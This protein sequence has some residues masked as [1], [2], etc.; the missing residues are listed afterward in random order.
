MAAPAPLS[1]SGSLPLPRTRL[2][3]RDAERVAARALLL[4][5]AVPLLTL[6]GPGG[7]GKTR[8]ALQVAADL[9]EEFAD[10]VFFVPLATIRDADAFLPTVARALGLGDMGSR[11]LQERLVELVQPRQMLLVLDNLEQ[12]TA[13]APLIA[14]LLTASPRLT[15]LA[16]S[17]TVLYLSAEH[18]LPISPLP[19]SV[20][21]G[22]ATFAQIASADAVRLFVDRARAA[23]PDFVLTESNAATVA[24]ICARL[25]GLPL[26]I[27][28]A[29][30]RVGHLPLPAILSRLEE[31]LTFLTGG[32]RD[33]PD[34][35]RTLRNAMTWSYDLLPADEQRLLRSLAVFRGGFSLE[36][37]EDVGGDAALWGRNG[38]QRMVGAFG[39][40]PATLSVL[41][42]HYPPKAK[43]SP[44][45]RR[46]SP[47]VFEGLASL[48]DKS[49]IRLDEAAQEPRY[50]MLE[51]VREFAFERL[52]AGGEAEVVQFAHLA[53]FLALAE[54]AAPEWWGRE[55][56]A[57][58]DRLASE[59]D[60]LRAALGWAVERGQMALGVRL[61]IALHW[62]WR[63]RGPVHEGRHWTA[64]MLLRCAEV[65]PA[66]HAALLPRA[67]DLAT[68]QGDFTRARA[69]LD[70]GIAMARE[71]DDPRLLTFALG[72]RGASAYTAGD[73]GFARTCLEEA[74]SLARANAV[75]L[76]NALAAALLA[77]VSIQLGDT[78]R[79]AELIADVH[80]S[81]RAGEI[82]WTT[83]LIL[84]IEGFLAADHG[85]FDRANRLYRENVTLAWAMRDHRFFPGAVTGFAWTAAARGDP[86]L[87][88]R[89]CGAVDAYRAVTG[90]YLT[91]TGQLSYERALALGQAAI[92]EVACEAAREAGRAL[93]PEAI[94]AEVN[95]KTSAEAGTGA[96]QRTLP[97]E[98]YGLTPRE[99][100]VLRLMAQGRTNR[101]IADGLFISHRTATTHVTNILG[102][103]GVSSRTEATAWAVR[104]GLA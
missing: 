102:K 37:A 24:A 8:L 14:D 15:I 39:A 10:G 38:D 61:A 99:R 94:L 46:D 80:A 70:A 74:V 30:A 72:M 17:Q 33:K 3:G 21:T 34:R 91:R 93:R 73:D 62:F 68:V 84:N 87:A 64:T 60:N 41:H 47:S 40:D 75:P 90:V 5:E 78:G 66:L 27:E 4:D 29:A 98:G 49:L 86:A 95:R 22:E 51:T 45:E 103:I 76:W 65:S 23:R 1:G 85:D 92:G 100:E 59:H 57:W 6:T 7:V 12:L 20:E 56:A 104:E 16:T 77:G 97:G 32:A 26:A 42:P 43:P 71:L 81:S 55:P 9:R 31:R 35:L 11:P 67:G 25:D 52:E 69:M 82:M 96:G 48:V 58:L 53:H 83:T 2:I 28:L 54:R 18:D 89:L 36:A 50:R 19:L 79:A 101:E 88:C 13:A 44:P 63:L